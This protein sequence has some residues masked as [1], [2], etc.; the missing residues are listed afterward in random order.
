MLE[1]IFVATRKGLFILERGGDGASYRIA[2][3]SFVGDPVTM[4]LPDGRDGTLADGAVDTLH[5]RHI[6][7]DQMTV[8]AAERDTQ[9][10][11]LKLVCH[12]FGIRNRLFL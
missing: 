10:A 3:S 9:S 4:V 12:R 6:Y 2:R 1:S 8:R 7:V 11:L 5:A